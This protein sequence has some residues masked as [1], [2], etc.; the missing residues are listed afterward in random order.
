MQRKKIGDKSTI[1]DKIQKCI[2]CKNKFSKHKRHRPN[3]F[4]QMV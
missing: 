1:A 4:K 3:L 2:K